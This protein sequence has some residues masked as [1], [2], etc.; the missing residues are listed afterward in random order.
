MGWIVG[1][2]RAKHA[3]S[4]MRLIRG[5]QVNAQMPATLPALLD[6]DVTVLVPSFRRPRC[7]QRCIDFYRGWVRLV[8]VDGTPNPSAPQ[9]L[10]AGITYISMPDTPMLVRLK[11]GMEAVQTSVVVPS[12]DDD[13]LNPAFAKAALDRFERQAGLGSLVGWFADFNRTSSTSAVIEP[14]YVEHYVEFL[15]GGRT[16]GQTVADRTRKLLVS[17]IQ[18]IWA[19]H[20]RENFEAFL[21]A[22]DGLNYLFLEPTA[23]LV[24]ALEG[25]VDILDV[26]QSFREN[27]SRAGRVKLD[28]MREGWSAIYRKNMAELG[29]RYTRL[30]GSSNDRLRWREAEAILEHQIGERP[31]GALLSKIKKT[32]DVGNGFSFATSVSLDAT[33][34]LSDD[35]IAAMRSLA[36]FLFR[37]R[38]SVRHAAAIGEGELYLSTIDPPRPE[39]DF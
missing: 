24:V 19:A 32:V 33:P 17:P 5:D 4:E 3:N 39:V 26:I 28:R 10:P 8:I 31:K 11:A 29:E 22:G 15:N 7:L 20:R 18:W 36:D 1:G 27:H 9:D 25:D 37:R 35:S 2:G 21:R 16:A 30:A 23:R 12:A 13:I 6:R 38:F 14:K 34:Y